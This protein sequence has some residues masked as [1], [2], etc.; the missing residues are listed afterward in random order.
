MRGVNKVILVGNLGHDVEVRQ[1]TNGNPVANI[2]IATNERWTRRDTGQVQEHTE[3]HNVVLFGR[4]AEL[5]HQYLQKGSRIYVEGR[6]RTRSWQDR[7][8]QERRST[9][10]VA[11][12]MQFLD[13]RGGDG[14]YEQHR[15]SPP[16]QSNAQRSS[17]SGA[18]SDVMDDEVPF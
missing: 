17:V 1:M 8:G 2:R 18:D 7:E 10:V 12:D 6:L 5:A 9:E 13:R 4:R 3:W 11:D 14:D 15:S 16:A